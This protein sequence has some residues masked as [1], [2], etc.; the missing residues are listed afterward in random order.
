[1]EIDLN[2]YIREKSNDLGIDILGFTN[3][4]NLERAGFYLKERISRGDFTEFEDRE[5]KNR[6][7]PK[8][9]LDSCRSII[10]IGISYNYPKKEEKR[11]FNYKG[12]LS[13]SSLGEDYH[14]VLRDKMEELVLEINRIEDFE[15]KIIVDTSPLLDREL[16]RKSG[17]GYFGKNCSIINEDYGSFIFLGH[18]LTDLELR[19]NEHT[20]PS[21]CGTCRICLD[22][23][24]TGA[25]E[26]AYYL[27][28]NRCISYLTQTREKIDEDLLDKMGSQI[29]GCDVCQDVCPRNKGVKPSKNKEFQSRIGNYVDLE[30]IFDM[31]NREFKEKYGHMAGSWRGRNIFKRN[32]II[33]LANQEE[34]AGLKLL[35]RELERDDERFNYYLNWAI[36]K[37]ESKG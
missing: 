17:L 20:R 19:I 23:C 3:C 12:K 4:K 15:Y 33:A 7:D 10:S 8:R 18:I 34:R 22:A 21:E 37:I 29:Y 36:K 25:L 28:P 11:D 26:E 31:S 6:T 32:A 9:Q 5:I 1:M 14:R 16:A 27:N 13:K 2:N 30:E 24:P 35:Y